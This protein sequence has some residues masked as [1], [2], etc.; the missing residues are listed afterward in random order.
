MN[1]DA[2]VV[3][4]SLPF[5]RLALTARLASW[6]GYLLFTLTTLPLYRSIIE[7]THTH[8]NRVLMSNLHSTGN[9]VACM[10][11]EHR[12]IRRIKRPDFLKNYREPPLH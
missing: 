10:L 9:I 11:I 2:H 8:I 6:D 7:H 3:L 4:P 5:G 1:A 12:A